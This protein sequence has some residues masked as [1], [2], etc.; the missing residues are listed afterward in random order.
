MF[1]TFVDVSINKQLP[2]WPEIIMDAIAIDRGWE[3]LAFIPRRKYVRIYFSYKWFQFI[4]VLMLK[5]TVK[6]CEKRLGGK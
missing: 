5:R 6:N 1:K 4:D 3:I 2:L